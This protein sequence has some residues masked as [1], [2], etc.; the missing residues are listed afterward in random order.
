MKDYKLK[1]YQVGLGS[2]AA[3]SCPL[4]ALVV[5]W[6]WKEDSDP[7]K[8]A[9]ASRLVWGITIG[10]IVYAIYFGY[11]FVTGFIDGIKSAAVK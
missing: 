8:R 7:K 11:G 9:L 2:L 1:W 4:M 3:L 6:G 10:I 5:Y